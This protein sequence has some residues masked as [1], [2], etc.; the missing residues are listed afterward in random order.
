MGG[1]R[2]RP[3]KTLS[4]C[5]LASRAPRWRTATGSA[6]CARRRDRATG[7][8]GDGARPR[9]AANGAGCQAAHRAKA[10]R[11]DGDIAPYRNGTRAWSANAKRGEGARQWGTSVERGNGARAWSAAMGYERG[12]RARGCGRGGAAR[13]GNFLGCNGLVHLISF[14]TN[15]HGIVKCSACEANLC[16]KMRR[17]SRFTQQPK[18]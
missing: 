15:T 14:A 2:R 4:V 1:A 6:W 10:R 13:W 16:R 8:H 11:R 7:P 18:I 9:G 17:K 3:R 5:Y 12:A